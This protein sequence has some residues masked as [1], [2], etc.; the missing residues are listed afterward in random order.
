MDK[1]PDWLH[2]GTMLRVKRQSIGMGKEAMDI[3]TIAE[4][5]LVRYLAPSWLLVELDTGEQLEVHINSLERVD[6]NR[7]AD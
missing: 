6:E 2:P 7:T 5:R 1:K 3:S 4:G